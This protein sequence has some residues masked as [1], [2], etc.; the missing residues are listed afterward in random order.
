MKNKK[1]KG[2]FTLVEVLTV[3]AIIAIV[4]VIALITFNSKISKSK[5]VTSSLAEKNIMDASLDY[6]KEFGESLQ[7]WKYEY[8]EDGNPNTNSKYYC[9][10]VGELIN[11]GYFDD[12]I[13]DDNI[14]FNNYVRLLKDDVKKTYDVSKLITPGVNDD[15]S[16]ACDIYKVTFL[17]KDNN[18]IKIGDKEYQIE[19]PS[20]Y[21]LSDSDFPNINSS[22]KYYSF[23]VGDSNF[24]YNGKWADDE[25]GSIID[26]GYVVERDMVLKIKY[27]L[28]SGI[29]DAYLLKKGQQ[30]PFAGES[31]ES[32]RYSKGA[33]IIL[34]D[35]N[36]TSLA[37]FVLKC[38]DTH[39]C[40]LA[41]GDEDI[42]KFLT[43]ETS[44][45]LNDLKEK[46][47]NIDW[48]VLKYVDGTWHL[49]GQVQSD[50][51][52]GFINLSRLDNNSFANC[53]YIDRNDSCNYS[54]GYNLAITVYNKDVTISSVS[55]M[56]KNF[57]TV[58]YSLDEL[59]KVENNDKIFSES[60]GYYTNEKI[61]KDK[62]SNINSVVIKYTY[63]GVSKQYTYEYSYNGGVYIFGLN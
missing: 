58:V 2:G 30:R 46:N 44:E 16:L 29:G 51:I 49:D 14:K 19:V 18:I 34:S 56:F 24:V 54:D 52:V 33:D 47:G 39:N 13:L 42:Y 57:S 63:N 31:D 27:S 36:G 1:L 17:D 20:G 43:K 38:S 40:V 22:S 21:K 4:I 53:K 15:V 12:S 28:A 61:S 23:Q 35:N 6:I 25:L 3:I 60:L 5:E 9:V 7:N 50:F 10:T 41:L 45:K 62:A 26:T 8:D 55:V 37:D 59:T 11:K 48:Y 32:T